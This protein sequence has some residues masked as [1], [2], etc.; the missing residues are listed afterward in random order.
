[1]GQTSYIDIPENVKQSS[2]PFALIPG[3]EVN[4]PA[5]ATTDVDGKKPQVFSFRNKTLNK[6]SQGK[7]IGLLGI[8]PKSFEK[9]VKN[10]LSYQLL[11]N[12]SDIGLFPS[13]SIE[14]DTIFN[15]IPAIQ[16]REFQPESAVNYLCSLISL[17]KDK[18]LSHSEKVSEAPGEEAD[19]TI[20]VEAVKQELEISIKD[21][22]DNIKAFGSTIWKVLQWFVKYLVGVDEQDSIMTDLKGEIAKAKADSWAS[23]LDDKVKTSILNFP[24]SM[25]YRFMTTTTTNIY[26][27]PYISSGNQ[28]IESDGAAGWG[29]GKVDIPL[30]GEGL[31]G[32]I[33]KT[34]FGNIRVNYISPW[35]AAEGHATMGDKITVE[36]DLFNDNIE[37]AIN[38]FIFVNTI[39][40]N[41]RWFQYNFFQNP[42]SLYDIKIEGCNRLFA[43]TGQ[44]AVSYKGILRDPPY[45]F[46]SRLSLKNKNTRYTFNIMQLLEN[47]VVK[48]PDIYHVKM[49][50]QSCIPQNFN[51]WLFQYSKENLNHIDSQYATNAVETN[52]MSDAVKDLV[53]KF[54]DRVTTE[55]G[56]A[57]G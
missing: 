32:S 47:K 53:L 51:T 24:Y 57:K 39:I 31:L 56:K 43:C 5:N 35:D 50:F 55:Y 3:K 52:I 9:F 23:S 38:N 28:M 10:D 7:G 17:L 22:P 15:S 46:V 25:Y 13:E 16:I 19:T 6:S 37:K 4:A 42:S 44:F 2:L 11:Y 8:C 30:D 18:L 12:R 49:E 48:I 21:F 14:A 34:L 26:E 36:V 27:L 33:A 1:M 29:A 54:A 41:N 40:P 20:G 45:T